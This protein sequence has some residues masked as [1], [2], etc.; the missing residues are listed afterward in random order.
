[1]RAYWSSSFQGGQPLS[2]L[3]PGQHDTAPRI[4][5]TRSACGVASLMS[6][7]D[8][9]LFKQCDWGIVSTSSKIGGHTADIMLEC[10]YFGDIFS[11]LPPR[12]CP[13]NFAFTEGSF[14]SLL[15]ATVI[16][17]WWNFKGI[18]GSLLVATRFFKN[19]IFPARMGMSYWHRPCVFIYLVHIRTVLLLI[20]K[21]LYIT[22]Q[23]MLQVTDSN[24]C[25]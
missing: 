22:W 17:T 4:T 7:W 5:K 12:V 11:Q 18:A 16:Q 8:S 23:A 3:F 1:M 21:F 25:V 20:L 9:N 6:G 14:P 10:D 19:V 15:T 13:A 2:L 24:P